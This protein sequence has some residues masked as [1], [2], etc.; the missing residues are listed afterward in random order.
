MRVVH[1][2]YKYGI[3]N[4]GGAAIAST[5]LHMALLD[6]GVKSH[7]VTVWTCED[8]TNVHVLPQ[9]WRRKLFFALTKVTR[10]VW[11]F[12]PYRK[13]IPLNIVPMFGLEKLLQELKPDVVHVQWI[14]ADVCSFEQLGNLRQV[15][16][17]ACRIVFNLH[18][19]YVLLQEGGYP[20][21]DDR[22][23]IDGFN[24][25]NSTLLERWLFSRKHRMITKCHPAFIGPS[26]WV[27]E[28]CEKSIV[29][30]GCKTYPISNIINPIFKYDPSRNAKHDKFV[31]LFGCYGGR[32]NAYKGW[33]DLVRALKLLPPEIAASM[34]VS[35]FGENGTDEII[36]GIEVHVVGNVSNPVDLV[37]IYHSA[38]VF[39]FP[40]VQ[41]TQ[42]MTKCE[43]MFCGLPV[44]TFNRTACGEGIEHKCTGWIAK[45]GDI[46]SY[47]DGLKF[48]LRR[49][50]NPT[51]VAQ[52]ASAEFGQKHNIERIL[53]CYNEG[54][55]VL[56]PLCAAE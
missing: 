32:K 33:S 42:G 46:Q 2:G 45:D 3:N 15:V 14:N 28:E 11:K 53:Q 55:G 48:F 37:D 51:D 16:G 13:S 34:Q 50:A 12:T 17:D 18:D 10:C 38:D 5:R 26:K 35:V 39:V 49:R 27:C 40:S 31:L 9:G 41:E 47:A 24:K 1:I 29:G 8:G 22:R 25:D 56:N 6:A 20:I 44:L 23:Y 52:S 7:Y 43:A 54:H 30:R 19:L 4:T 36:N 21:R